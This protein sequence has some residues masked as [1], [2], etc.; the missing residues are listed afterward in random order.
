MDRLWQNIE[1][2]PFQVPAK[3]ETL[4]NNKHQDHKR[5][6]FIQLTSVFSTAIE[7]RT[8]SQADRTAH[9]KQVL[10]LLLID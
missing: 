8:K 6:F 4:V 5:S 2:T 3:R 1:K 7:M 9:Y 10:T